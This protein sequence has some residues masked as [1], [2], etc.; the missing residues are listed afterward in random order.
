MHIVYSI[1]NIA[2]ILC[3]Y[4]AYI[5]HLYAICYIAHDIL[6]MLHHILECTIY[7]ILK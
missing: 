7:Y 5:I 3:I 1:Y 4:C 2:Y 6:Y